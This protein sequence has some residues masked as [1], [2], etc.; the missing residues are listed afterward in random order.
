MA[1]IVN[2]L[3]Y[4]ERAKALLTLLRLKIVAEDAKIGKDSTE[5]LDDIETTIVGLKIGDKFTDEEMKE[6]Y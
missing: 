4:V 5:L 3:K 1:S 2:D 6:R